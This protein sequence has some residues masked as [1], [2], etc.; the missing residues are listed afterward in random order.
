M[1]LGVFQETKV[2]GII[3]IRVLD[4]YSVIATDLPIRHWGGVVMFY[5]NSLRFTVESH[6]HF[7]HNVIRFHM[8]S[9][10]QW[11]YIVGCYFAPEYA[12]TI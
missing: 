10:G 11:W 8:A 2:N 4:G 3:Y 12:L 1:Y 7:G 9:G 5:R 6:Q